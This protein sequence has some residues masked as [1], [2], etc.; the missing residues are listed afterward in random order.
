MEIKTPAIM[1]ALNSVIA[2][3]SLVPER[4]AALEIIRDLILLQQKHINEQIL[5]IRALHSMLN[6]LKRDIENLQRE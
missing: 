4:R 2:D 1:E 6:E 5:K 3:S